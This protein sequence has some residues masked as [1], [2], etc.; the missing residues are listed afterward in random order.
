MHHL[1]AKYGVYNPSFGYRRKFD[2]ENYDKLRER[3][4]EANQDAFSQANCLNAERKV[5]KYFPQ[6]KTKSQNEMAVA[7]KLIF[8]GRQRL[9][10]KVYVHNL[11][12]N[13]VI[14]DYM[15]PQSA[16]TL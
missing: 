4:R 16:V 10:S 12:I 3:M 5:K 14:E 1:F 11:K 2:P 6:L 9:V 13:M 15:K 7:K 8:I